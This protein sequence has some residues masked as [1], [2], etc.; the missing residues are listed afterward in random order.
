MLMF[1]LR[2]QAFKCKLTVRGDGCWS[3][4]CQPASINSKAKPLY[5]L[6]AHPPVTARKRHNNEPSCHD[7]NR[8]G[9]VSKHLPPEAGLAHIL[10]LTCVSF[11]L[12][13]H[14]LRVH[15]PVLT[16]CSGSSPPV[17]GTRQAAL[18]RWLGLGRRSPARWRQTESSLVRPS[19]RGAQT[20]RRM[21]VRF[22][23]LVTIS[24]NHVPENFALELAHATPPVEVRQWDF[25][26]LVT[27]LKPRHYDNCS[28]C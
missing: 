1:L 21:A 23:S 15:G 3:P 6:S 17:P 19:F 10:G 14:R 7:T 2:L 9:E 27:F 25:V 18:S 28:L 26:L 22:H 8:A 20:D 24:S 5:C 11:R 4:T 12:C 16:R 13:V